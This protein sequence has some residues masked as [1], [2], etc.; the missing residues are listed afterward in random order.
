M[1][2]KT[3]S[4][5]LK[6]IRSVFSGEPSKKIKPGVNFLDETL[7]SLFLRGKR[8][9]DVL[10]VGRGEE[11]ADWEQFK[12]MADFHYFNE[13]G[14]DR[15]PV[16]DPRLVIVGK[17]WFL[18]RNIFNNVEQWEYIKTPEIVEIPGV[19]RSVRLAKE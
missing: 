18:R 19:L 14:Q 17:H 15:L 10:W 16:I 8:V 13:V 5:T 1:K 6:N 11:I 9:E 7:F 2:R 4:I 12:V 3:E